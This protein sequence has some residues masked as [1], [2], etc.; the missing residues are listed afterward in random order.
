MPTEAENYSACVQAIKTQLGVLVAAVATTSKIYT[1]FVF[2]PD[3][4]AWVGLLRSPDDIVSGKQRVN[5][6][7]IYNEAIDEDSNEDTPVGCIDPVLR[8]GMAFYEGFDLGTDTD[9]SE[10]RITDRIAQVQ[11]ALA[12]SSDL[13][14]LTIDDETVRGCVANHNG[15]KV[16]RISMRMFGR[17]PVQFGIGQIEVE[18]QSRWVR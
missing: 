2:D 18:M 6:I 7:S 14:M 11:F 12:E 5:A 16:P 10:L 17:T 3:Q 4:D 1:R 8:F 13:G 9:N 15:L